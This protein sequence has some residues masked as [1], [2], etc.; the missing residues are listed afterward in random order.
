[1]CE[2][3]ISGEHLSDDDVAAFGAGE[4]QEWRRG[5]DGVMWYRRVESAPVDREHPMIHG[6]AEEAAGLD[7]YEKRSLQQWADGLRTAAGD[8]DEDDR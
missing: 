8:D 4:L 6:V 5:S 3:F 7:D 2:L 1:M